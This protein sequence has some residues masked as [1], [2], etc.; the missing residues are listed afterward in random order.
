MPGWG[1][2]GKEGGE[3]KETTS[4]KKVEAEE[5]VK[6]EAPAVTS[7]A[8]VSAQPVVSVG[9]GVAVST[10]DSEGEEMMS[11][12]TETSLIT[13]SPSMPKATGTGMVTSSVVASSIVLDEEAGN[14]TSGSR[15]GPSKGNGTVPTTGAGSK[16]A[17]GYSFMG[18]MALLAAVAI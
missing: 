16:A 14:S 8:V 10:A 15:I 4:V 1:P 13:S 6:P 18:A 7:K 17:V 11:I 9:S 3:A 5:T 2:D 12:E